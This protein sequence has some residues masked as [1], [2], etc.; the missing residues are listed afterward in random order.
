MHSSEIRDRLMWRIGKTTYVVLIK[1]GDILNLIVDPGLGKPWSSKLKKMAD[2]V[3]DECGG[4]ACT[5]DEAWSLL[6]KHNM[7]GDM[8]N[9]ERALIDAIA[10]KAKIVKHKYAKTETTT[11]LDANGNPVN[12]P[13]AK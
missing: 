13:R 1:D 5:F 7:K 9:L 11:I 4:M 8:G 2:Q 12:S 3:A 6:I 10:Q